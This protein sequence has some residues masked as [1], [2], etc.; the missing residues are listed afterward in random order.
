[1]WKIFNTTPFA[2]G[3]SFRQENQTGVLIWMVAVKASFQIEPTT[4]FLSIAEEQEL[5]SQGEQFKGE[6]TNSGLLQNSDFVLGKEKVDILLNATAY[7]P[8]DEPVTEMVAGFDLG[9]ISKSLKI[10]GDREY[11]KSLGF[12]I[13]TTPMPF[14]KMPIV[15]ENAY[16]GWQ[17]TQEDEDPVYEIRNPAGIGFSKKRKYR[18]GKNLPN[19]EYLKYPTKKR[20]RKNRV[21]GFGPIPGHWAPRVDFAGKLLNTSERPVSDFYPDDFNPLFH[22]YAPLDQQADQI[23]GKEEVILY[24]L[25]PD[26]EHISFQLPLVEIRFETYIDTEIVKHNGT[27]Q[28]IYIEPDHNRLQM[29]WLGSLPCTRKE[30][31]LEYTRVNSKIIIND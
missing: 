31:S 18:P 17:E 26:H 5:P 20:P 14:A 6:A 12:I 16:G 25:H 30:E 13:Q 28:T 23:S 19:I 21:A 27:L 24:N 29:V 11:Q 7:S 2:T 1:M 10:I 22:Q 3:S 15:Y 4:G 8:M 9:P